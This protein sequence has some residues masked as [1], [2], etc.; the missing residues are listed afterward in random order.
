MWGRRGGGFARE[1]GRAGGGSGRRRRRGR[2]RRPGGR[3]TRLR[4]S[5][6]LFPPFPAVCEAARTGRQREVPRGRRC[7]RPQGGRPRARTLGRAPVHPARPADSCSWTPALGS[8]LGGRPRAPPHSAPSGSSR[9][10]STPPALRCRSFRNCLLLARPAPGCFFHSRPLLL[11]STLPPEFWGERLP[12]GDERSVLR[13]RKKQ[14]PQREEAQRA[15]GRRPHAALSGHL[16]S[17]PAPAHTPLRASY[18]RTRKVRAA[19][20]TAPRGQSRGIA[21]CP[22]RC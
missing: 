9:S 14:G 10:T 21:S 12:R 6:A 1:A 7:C 3:Q 2:R 15:V 16:S 11:L 8:R 19:L 17:R 13:R 22:S 18:F 5:P 4:P 20:V